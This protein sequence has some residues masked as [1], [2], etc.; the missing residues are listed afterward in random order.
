MTSPSDYSV[1]GPDRNH[2]V[3]APVP[4]VDQDQRLPNR[5]P[6]NGRKRKRRPKADAKDSAPATPSAKPPEEPTPPAGQTSEDEHVV[7]TL[8]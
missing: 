5:P 6:P 1:R 3:A 8:A 4:V 7:D 2:E